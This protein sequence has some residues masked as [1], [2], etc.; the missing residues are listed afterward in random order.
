MFLRRSL[1]RGVIQPTD[2]ATLPSND[3]GYSAMGK[4]AGAAAAGPVLADLPG[5]IAGAHK[6]RGLGRAFLRH[7]RRTRAML[8][9]VDASGGVC[10]IFF[11][12]RSYYYGPSDPNLTS[13]SE[14]EMSAL[15]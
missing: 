12:I 15:P 10:T 9:V 6:G 2:A 14:R 8:V 4:G 1:R 3:Y 5:L 13:E 7:L 11:D